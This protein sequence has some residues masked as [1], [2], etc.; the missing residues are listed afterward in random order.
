MAGAGFFSFF[1][2]LCIFTNRFRVQ[3]AAA[4]LGVASAEQSKGGWL[5]LAHLLFAWSNSFAWGE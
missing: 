3:P 4:M 5:L 1:L 2:L